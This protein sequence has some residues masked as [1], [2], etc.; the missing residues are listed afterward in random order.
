MKR[1][2]GNLYVTIKDGTK[3]ISDEEREKTLNLLSKWN[4]SEES[5][6]RTSPPGEDRV[7]LTAKSTISREL[8]DF[9]DS[10]G[11]YIVNNHKY[12]KPS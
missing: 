12:T 1:I 8:V 9:G 4:V 11:E 7:L 10:L 2:H 6:E 3:A 5:K